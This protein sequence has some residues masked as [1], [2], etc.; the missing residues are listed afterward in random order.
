MQ[1]ADLQRQA[2]GSDPEVVPHNTM[3][4]PGKQ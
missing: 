2:V 1:P 4:V 3:S